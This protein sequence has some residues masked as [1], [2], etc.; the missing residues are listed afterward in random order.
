[1]GG[2]L[3][4]LDCV[5]TEW[6]EKRRFAFKATTPTVKAEWCYTIEPTEGGCRVTFE[7]NLEL[8]GFMAEIMDAFSL[9]QIAQSRNIL[10]Q[11][12]ACF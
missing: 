10:Q 8:K 7:K 9:E 6:V 1:M 12:Y 11:G 3:R 5:I 4:K 2:T